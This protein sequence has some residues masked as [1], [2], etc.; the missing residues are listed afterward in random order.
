MKW[1][2]ARNTRSSSPESADIVEHIR[3]NHEQSG[4]GAGTRTPPGARRNRERDTA[5]R[6]RDQHEI[7][8]HRHDEA[9][10]R[11]GGRGGF[12]QQQPAPRAQRDACAGADDHDHQHADRPV[13]RRAAWKGTSHK[14]IDELRLDFFSRFRGCPDREADEGEHDDGMR[15]SEQHHA[16]ERSG[17]RSSPLTQE[18]GDEVREAREQAGYVESPRCRDHE[19]LD[20]EQHA[21]GGDEEQPV[22][23]QRVTRECQHVPH[24]EPSR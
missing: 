2:E 6:Q 22:P 13:D 18:V 4:D 24:A 23:A 1:R 21:H 14:H 11:R 20:Q 17:D 15:M 9:H 7:G 3:S 5:P 19:D 12:Q 16:A 10:W 8:G